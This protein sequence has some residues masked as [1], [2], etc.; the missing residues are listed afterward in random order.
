MSDTKLFPLEVNGSEMRNLIQ[1]LELLHAKC[2]DN[3]QAIKPFDKDAPMMKEYFK[4]KSQE[5]SK[6][7]SE[8]NKILM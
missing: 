1:G 5:L 7:I 6:Q 2:I 4:G 3:I 8:L